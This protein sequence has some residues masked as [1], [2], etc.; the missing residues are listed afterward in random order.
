LRDAE[1]TSGAFS[2]ESNADFCLGHAANGGQQYSISIPELM[3]WMHGG[4]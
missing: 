4:F 2:G 1:F 3:Y